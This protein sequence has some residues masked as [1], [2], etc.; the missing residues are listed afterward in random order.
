MAALNALRLGQM[1]DDETLRATGE[2]T[3]QAFSEQLHTVPSAMPQILVGLD[4]ALAKPK[5]FV[6]AGA[7]L[8]LHPLLQEFHAHFIPN[9]VILFADGGE[10][11]Q[12]LGQR[13]DFIKTA[14]PVN[15]KPT[16]YICEDFACRTPLSTAEDLRRML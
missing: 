7:P 2:K 13:L 4:F 9:K 11:Q 6:F 5:Q 10:G 3:I 15:R 12:W 16:A 14:I 8:E 1:L